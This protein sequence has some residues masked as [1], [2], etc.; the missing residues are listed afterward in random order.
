VWFADLQEANPALYWLLIA[1]MLGVL[2][3]LVGHILYTIFGVLRAHAEL[4]T[5]EESATSEPDS[6]ARALERA[7]R[8]AGGGDTVAGLRELYVALMRVVE[9][10]H[11]V[12]WR[13]ADTHR[14]TVRKLEA[15]APELADA[16]AELGAL[17]D[18]GWFGMRPVSEDEYRRV[19]ARIGEAAGS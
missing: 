9:L 7:D 18:E 11:G 10:R 12:V 16:V 8:H 17:L 14:E 6:V 1:A 2:A 4:T 3:L 15:T 5:V 13:R 19:R